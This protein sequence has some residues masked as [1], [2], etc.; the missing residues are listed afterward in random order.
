VWLTA[1]GYVCA[2]FCA[3]GWLRERRRIESNQRLN[4]ER[5]NVAEQAARFG[6][7]EVDVPSGVVVLSAGAALLSGLPPTLNRT[8]P[9]VIRRSIHPDDLKVVKP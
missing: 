9:S 6:I 3:L 8:T 7:W 5:R 2:L 4:L 1:I